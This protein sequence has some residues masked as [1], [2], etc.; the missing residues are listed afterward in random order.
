MNCLFCNI[1]TKEI[2]AR[3]VYEDDATLAFLDIHPRTMGHTVI[4]PKTHTENIV[5]APEAL[6]TP[7]FLTVKKIT[8]M[9]QHTLSPKGFTIGINHGRISG[10]AVDHLHV[11]VIPRYEGDGG[12]SIHSV[13]NYSSLLSLDE[14]AAKIKQN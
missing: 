11:H 14:V 6:I 2:S 3:I 8:V 7:T 5:M 13:V 12:G 10:Q 4:I 9:L 1:A